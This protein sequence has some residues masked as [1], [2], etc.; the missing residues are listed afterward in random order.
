MVYVGVLFTIYFY[1]DEVFVHICGY[2]CIFKAFPLHYMAPVTGRIA[3]TYDYRFLF[4]FCTLKGRIAP[5]IPVYRV[6]RVLLQIRTL[7]VC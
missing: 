6:V 2:F 3:N 7:L 1:T 4:G 5:G